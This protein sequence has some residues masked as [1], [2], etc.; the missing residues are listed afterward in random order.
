M[1]KKFI[2]IYIGIENEDEYILECLGLLPMDADA[3]ND[4]VADRDPHALAFFELEDAS[5]DELDEW[6]AY[7]L[8][9][10]PTIAAFQEDFEPSN[11]F[12]GGWR[13]HVE[14]V[15]PNE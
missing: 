9:E 8:D 2:D 11:P 6:D 1:V 7:D 10:L 12:D 14:F 15:D 3:L 4:L 5:E 13:L